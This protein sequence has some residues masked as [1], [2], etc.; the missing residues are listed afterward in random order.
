MATMHRIPGLVDIESS[1]EAAK[2]TLAVDI[3]RELASDLGHGELSRLPVPCA[4]SSPVK[5]PEPGRL[6]M[7]QNYDIT[8]RLPREER[9]RAANLDR[10]YLTSTLV[11]ADGSPRMVSLGRLPSSCRRSASPRSTARICIAK[12]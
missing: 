6:R 7:G 8:V 12:S 10:L 2:P 1:L 3:N 9:A 11:D 4:P 5:S